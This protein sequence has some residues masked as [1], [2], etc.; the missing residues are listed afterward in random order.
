MRH[1][2][3]G[4]VPQTR[5]GTGVKPGVA[6]GVAESV[7]VLAGKGVARPVLSIE[8]LEFSMDSGQLLEP[9]PVAMRQHRV[10]LNQAIRSICCLCD[11][12]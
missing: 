10:A 12:A 8:G 6:G 1:S 11:L 4:S 2:H 9:Q 5:S 7:G 3:S